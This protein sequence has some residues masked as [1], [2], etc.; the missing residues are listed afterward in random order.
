MKSIPVFVFLFLAAFSSVFSQEKTQ[1]E[2]LSLDENSLTSAKLKIEKSA[3]VFSGSKTEKTAQTQQTY[4]RPNSERRFKRYVNGVF[5]PYALLGIAAGAGIST[6]TNEPEE[7]GKKA[8][9]FGRRV[10]SN[11]GKNVIKETVVYGLDEALKLDSGF[12][13]SQQRDTGSRVKNALLSTVTARKPNGKRVV[14]IPRLVGTY[15]S[16]IIA[17]ETWYP[18]R[19]DY[20]DGLRNGTI[21]LGIN[22][23]FN[24]FREFVFKK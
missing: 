9:G 23:A 7:W 13:R 4:T 20:K 10:A 5:G 6:A 18:S 17:A 12:Y 16:Q 14:G 19:Y 21:S 1:F 11:F 15:T 8:E 2:N 22:A 3:S 24:L